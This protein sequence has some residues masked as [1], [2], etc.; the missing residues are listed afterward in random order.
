MHNSTLLAIA[1]AAMVMVTMPAQAAWKTYV[2]KDLGISFQAPGDVKASIGTFRGEIAGPRQ[3]I[4]YRSMDDNIEYRVTIMS[5]HQ[6]QAEGATLLGERE[7]MFTNRKAPVA[8]TVAK[9]GSGKDAVFGRRI[10]T[11]LP[12]NKGRATAVFF[13]NRGKLITFEAIVPPNGNKAS[14]DPDR[15][16]DFVAFAPT[17]AQS[18]AVQLETPQL[19]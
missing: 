13:F 2:N 19:D 10:V 4:T 8:D 1:G 9:V 17:P 6:S 11:D 15:F 12:D 18:G 5:F 16:V 3:T 7:Y 14:P